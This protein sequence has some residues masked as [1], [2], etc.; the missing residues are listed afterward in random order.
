MGGRLN[1]IS[2][3]TPKR[4]V[5]ERSWPDDHYPGRF[6]SRLK[7]KLQRDPGV[8]RSKGTLQMRR[9]GSVTVVGGPYERLLPISPH[10]AVWTTDNLDRRE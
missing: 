2:Q 4:L 9:L 8:M 5:Q 3:R 7:T 1:D 6:D 10:A